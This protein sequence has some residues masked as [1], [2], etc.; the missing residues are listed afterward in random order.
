M[1]AVEIDALTLPSAPTG[2]HALKGL[3]PIRV[4]QILTA[5][6]DLY[7]KQVDRSLLF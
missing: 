6:M 5:E 1:T 3:A 4:P 2:S 7:A